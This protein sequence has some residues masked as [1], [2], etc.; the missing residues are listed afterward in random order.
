MLKKH[1]LALLAAVLA[2][3]L[4]AC[5]KESPGNRAATV[6]VSI[7]PGSDGTRTTTATDASESLVNDLQVFVFDSGGALDGYGHTTSAGQLTVRTVTGTHEVWAVTNAPD[8]SAVTSRNALLETAITLS[9][10]ATGDLIHAGGTVE[11]L[12]G[13]TTVR[14]V[15][16]HL[17]SRVTIRKITNRLAP[18]AVSS[19]PL[20]ITDLYLT[21]VV[22]DGSLG[23][24]QAPALWYNKM[25]LRN[26]LDRFLHDRIDA[27]D[28]TIALNG[29]YEREHRFYMMPNPTLTDSRSG[30]WCARCTRLVIR[31]E[32]GGE[33]YFY[34]VTLPAGGSNLS[35]D[36]AELVIGRIGVKD[37]ETEIPF[38]EIAY[39][40]DSVSPLTDDHRTLGFRPSEVLLVFGQPGVNPFDLVSEDVICEVT[41]P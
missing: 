23:G 15:P 22:G 9:G 27:A 5:Q 21:N 32:I 8:L 14:I 34:P 13:H 30:T 24:A 28:G 35:Y 12:S 29:S 20:V 7:D 39:G 18:E 11:E 26:E 41:N 17:V 10:Q 37:E 33:E 1:S 6:L 4:P 2:G 16:D 38:S 31:A 19:L 36:I 3:F 40:S 25:G